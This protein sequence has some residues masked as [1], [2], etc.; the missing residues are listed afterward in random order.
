MQ[1]T[2][3]SQHDIILASFTKELA[4]REKT[5]EFSLVEHETFVSVYTEDDYK[6]EVFA[7]YAVSGTCFILQRENVRMFPGDTSGEL[8]DMIVAYTPEGKYVGGCDQV[9]LLMSIGIT[10][11]VQPHS[12]QGG[13]CCIGFNPTEQ[14]WF[15]WSH[16]AIY[17]FGIG[18]KVEFGDCAYSP[19]D[20]EDAE[21]AMRAFWDEG[22]EQ[23]TEETGKTWITKIDKVVHNVEQEG[24]LGFTYYKESVC[25]EN[26]LESI[27]YNG[28]DPYPNPFGRGEW[29]AMSLDDAKQMAKDFASGVS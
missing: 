9:A 22:K 29:V 6:P 20:A 8:L 23:Y 13:T 10:E 2:T 3:T 25:K 12:E 1:Q 17:G 21:R 26:P 27:G 5:I 14:K 4:K 15:G 16:R 11:Q 7:A 18:S 24:M 19:K 28:F